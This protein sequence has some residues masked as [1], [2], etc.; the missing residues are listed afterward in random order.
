MKRFLK[1]YPFSSLFLLITFQIAWCQEYEWSSI[2]PEEKNVVS[3]AVDPTNAEII[4]AGCVSGYEDLSIL[5][6]IDGG[7]H[8]SEIAS[9]GYGSR[10]PIVIDPIQTNNVYVGARDGIY[11]TPDG[12]DTWTII[13]LGWGGYEVTSLAID[14]NVPGTI[15][16]G[17]INDDW[18]LPYGVFKST[19]GGLSWVAMSYDEPEPVLSGVYCLTLDPNASNIIYSGWFGGILKSTDAGTTWVNV[20]PGF[21]LQPVFALAIDPFDS[22]TFYAG[23][24]PDINKTLD[25]GDSWFLI[26]DS[27]AENGY[28]NS[29][30]IN[31]VNS[32]DIFVATNAGVFRS[33]I[34]GDQW[35]NVSEGLNPASISAIVFDPLS[36]NIIYAGSQGG[37][38]FKGWFSPNSIDLK[39]E[40]VDDDFSLFQNYPNPF[41]TATTISYCLPEVVGVKLAIYN[42]QGQ[43]VEIIVNE[44]QSIGF[45]HVT[46]DGRDKST[47]R[48][49][50]G[51]Y[52]CS[53]QIGQTVRCIKMIMLQ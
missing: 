34:G 8:W 36:D 42:V 35:Q 30:A 37:G 41:N 20:S 45:H 27:L 22:L 3:I 25:G 47:N 39:N 29:I 43:E 18:G 19:N 24:G 12:G 13:D 5:K 15:Y 48:V 53:L 6:T 9:G 4:Y 46:W 17:L 49:S 21:P 2:G 40:S 26:S 11:K 14:P 28:I 10:A 16:A 7:T 32:D 33:L 44:K 50:S 52:F 1:L 51:I 38:I 31:R 23:V